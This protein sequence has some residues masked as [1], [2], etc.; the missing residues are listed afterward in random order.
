MHK[1]SNIIV[2]TKCDIYYLDTLPNKIQNLAQIDKLVGR[3]MGSNS[4]RSS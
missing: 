3:I 1:A 2:G 4:M